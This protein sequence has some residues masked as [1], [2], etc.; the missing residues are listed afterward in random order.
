MWVT[1]VHD[2]VNNEITTIE[3][4]NS[5]NLSRK[6]PH[7][8]I[9]TRLN[10]CQNVRNCEKNCDFYYCHFST[11]GRWVELIHFIGIKMRVHSFVGEMFEVTNQNYAR[12]DVGNSIAYFRAVYN[13]SH[14][15]KSIWS[16]RNVACSVLILTKMFVNNCTH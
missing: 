15:D 8:L 2:Q 14:A 3:K 6:N 7:L 1:E 11:F 4:D 12:V 13:C 9:A 10:E 16:S 5:N